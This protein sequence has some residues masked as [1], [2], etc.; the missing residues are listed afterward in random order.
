MIVDCKSGIGSWPGESGG[1]TIR[2]LSEG[3]AGIVI[4]LTVSPVTGHFIGSG[5]HALHPFPFFSFLPHHRKKSAWLRVCGVRQ[6]CGRSV[7]I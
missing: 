7:Q 5:P 3:N 2:G 4:W 1:V 6:G